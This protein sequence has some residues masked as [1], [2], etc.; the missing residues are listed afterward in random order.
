MTDNSPYNAFD[1]HFSKGIVCTLASM[2]AQNS[3]IISTNITALIMYFITSFR[4][5]N[6]DSIQ[7]K[8]TYA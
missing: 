1:I 6:V 5:F 3:F 2:A 4:F 8:V 7:Y